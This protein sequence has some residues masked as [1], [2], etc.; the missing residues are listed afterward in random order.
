MTD[1]EPKTEEQKKKAMNF[2]EEVDKNFW[3]IMAES[4]EEIDTEEGRKIL[5]ERDLKI[6]LKG[7]KVGTQVFYNVIKIS[8]KYLE[9]K[10]DILDLFGELADKTCEV[11]FC[12]R[13]TFEDYFIKMTM[14]KK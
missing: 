2:M 11:V 6:F 14:G 8:L 13:D 1:E 7:V 5:I 10:K 3:E 12:M 9:L 4:M